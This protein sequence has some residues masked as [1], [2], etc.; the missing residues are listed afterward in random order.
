MPVYLALQPIR[1][2]AFHIAA[3]PG[4][5]LP[6]LFTLTRCTHACFDAGGYFLSRYSAVTDSFPLGSMVLYVA[7]TFLLPRLN[8]GKRLTVLL[9]MT[10]KLQNNSIP[11]GNLAFFLH[12]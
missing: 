11:A 10:T 3:E 6:R 12:Q 7:R 2:A 9:L 5:L 8:I 1:H 4:E